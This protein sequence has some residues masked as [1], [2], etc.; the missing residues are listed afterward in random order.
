MVLPFNSTSRVS[1]NEIK[2]L[3]AQRRNNSINTTFSNRVR[4]VVL[5]LSLYYQ[6]KSDFIFC[7]FDK[8]QAAAV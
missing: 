1:V 3:F 6:K 4:L 8:S 5:I 7:V 2:D